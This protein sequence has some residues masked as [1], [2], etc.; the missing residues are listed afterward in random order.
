MLDA[1]NVF[2]PFAF[3]NKKQP[4]GEPELMLRDHS[5]SDRGNPTI[6][7]TCVDIPARVLWLHAPVSWIFGI[8]RTIS[9]S[10]H[11]VVVVRRPT[12]PDWVRHDLHSCRL[13]CQV[14]EVAH[15]LSAYHVLVA[16]IPSLSTQFGKKYAHDNPVAHLCEARIRDTVEVY[17]LQDKKEVK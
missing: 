4:A 16:G 15:E 7:V 12:A 11:F 2:H 9:S 5:T 3:Y 1:V 13:N 8:G 14:V 10:E 17:L 6:Q